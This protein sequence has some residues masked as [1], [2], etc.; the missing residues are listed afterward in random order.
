MEDKAVTT[1]G[2]QDNGKVAERVAEFLDFEGERIRQETERIQSPIIAKARMEYK[3]RLAAFLKEESDKLKLEAENE[4]SSI[5]DKAKSEAGSIIAQAQ[6]DRQSIF[7]EAQKQV[8]QLIE[9]AKR[10]AIVERDLIVVEK[11]KEVEQLI[12]EAKRKSIMEREL[13]VKDGQMEAEAIISKAKQKASQ[14][15]AEAGELAKKAT[16]A[17]CEKILTEARK[18]A[19]D[20]SQTIITENWHRAQQMLNSAESAYN[21]VR[22]QLQNCVRTIIEADHKMEIVIAPNSDNT[23]ENTILTATDRTVEIVANERL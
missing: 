5:K 12:E 10:Q 21:L 23:P 14:L 22:T 8:D 1:D 20:Q 15:V 11:Q 19:H 7:M 6:A 2:V 16:E 13:I 17:E 18:K 9:E 4:A 3:Q